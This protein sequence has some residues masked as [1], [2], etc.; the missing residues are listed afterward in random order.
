MSA[1][2]LL[3]A[4]GAF[5][6]LV[7]VAYFTTLEWNLRLYVRERR[8]LAAVAAHAS[9]FVV[10]ALCFAAIA[11]GAGAGAL[12]AAFIGFL[13]TRTAA[14]RRVQKRIEGTV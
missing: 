13:L 5:G 6:A 12:L 4:F 1:L 3:L 8:G 14:V 10:T 7:G 11:R 2:A 9:R